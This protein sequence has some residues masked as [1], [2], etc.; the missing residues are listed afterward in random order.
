MSHPRGAFPH[1]AQSVLLV[2]AWLALQQSLAL[3]QLF[4]AALLGW[5]LPLLLHG[6]LGV[7]RGVRRWAPVPRFVLVVLRDIVVSNFVVARIVLSPWSKPQPAWVEVALAV[8]HPTAV[9]LLAT[10]ITT[11]PGTVSSVVDEA[12]RR[13]LV[14]ALDC[15]D[16][17]AM[18]A[19]IKTRYERPLQEIFE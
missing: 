17:A 4:T 2:L 6:F 19:D 9:M 16:P 15:D 12:G 5:G 13:I 18:A 11:T 1:P 10:I 3:P 7:S 14:H 8:S